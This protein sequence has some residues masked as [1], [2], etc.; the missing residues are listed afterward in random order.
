MSAPGRSGKGSSEQYSRDTFCTTSKKRLKT[1]KGCLK[2]N[3]NA[4]GRQASCRQRRQRESGI[5][6]KEKGGGDYQNDQIKE[7]NRIAQ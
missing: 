1:E 2:L 6:G 4:I 5:S 7:L 3:L